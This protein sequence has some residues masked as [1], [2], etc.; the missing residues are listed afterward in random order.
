[1]Y[2]TLP[3]EVLKISPNEAF[4]GVNLLRRGEI[5]GVFEEINQSSVRSIRG[6]KTMKEEDAILVMVD[7]QCREEFIAEKTYEKG[8]SDAWRHNKKY[9][10]EKFQAGDLV[11][12]YDNAL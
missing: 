11:H 6:K 10:P 7:H 2:M 9:T 12:V 8:Q 5:T 1:M 4:F 3:H